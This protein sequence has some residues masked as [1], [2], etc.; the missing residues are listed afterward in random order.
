MVHILTGVIERGTATVLRDLN[1][2][3]FGKTGTTSGPTNVWF[4]GG[5]PTS[6]P[7]P[8]SATTSRGRWAA[9]RRVAA[10]PRRS[11][12]NGRRQPQGRAPAPF[13]APQG[14]RMVR[15]DRGSG[16]PRVGTFPVREDPKSAVDL[17]KRSSPRANPRRTLRRA[18]R[19]PSLPPP[20][21]PA[22]PA[23]GLQPRRADTRA[24]PNRPGRRRT[25]WQGRAESTRTRHSV[26]KR[27]LPPPPERSRG[28]VG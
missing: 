16:P 23:A 28:R 17:G 7:A 1:R 18:A 9:R 24:G 11:S 2:P 10:L 5:T 22:L 6:S 26:R 13:V 14:I 12:S 25:S 3:L 4:V 15:I 27:G 8:T 19:R 20:R 21:H